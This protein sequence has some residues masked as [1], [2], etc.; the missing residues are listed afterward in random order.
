[1]RNVR[2]VHDERRSFPSTVWHT[3]AIVLCVE[4]QL[5]S[6]PYSGFHLRS[7][8]RS[9][10]LRSINGRPF[11]AVRNAHL[12]LVS[13][14]ARIVNAIARL[15]IGCASEVLL[16]Q[17]EIDSFRTTTKKV[18]LCGLALRV[19]P[20]TSG[21]S[22]ASVFPVR[23]NPERGGV[24]SVAVRSHVGALPGSDSLA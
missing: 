6:E 22:E 13:R 15:R 4:R 8:V 2:N 10:S 23:L 9:G 1:M 21:V 24:S 12:P 3:N 7:P 16:R 19:R 18:L 17:I 14:A 11:C 20:R 5:P